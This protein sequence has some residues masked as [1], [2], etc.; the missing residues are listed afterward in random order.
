[1]RG[2]LNAAHYTL[3][4]KRQRDPPTFESEPYCR[5]DIVS[6]SSSLLDERSD[7]T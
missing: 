6:F 3:Q 1:M 2:N 5:Y 4:Q 7:A